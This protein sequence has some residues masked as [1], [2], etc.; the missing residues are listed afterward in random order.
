MWDLPLR[1]QCG[2]LRGT[3]RGVAP[4]TVN[5]VACGCRYCQRYV[6]RLGCASRVLDEHGVSTIFQVSPASLEITEGLEQLE[7]LFQTSWGARR[8]FA[9]CCNSPLANTLRWRSVP[10]VGVFRAAADDNALPVPIEQMLGP[11]LA[12]CNSTFPEPLASGLLARRRDVFRM[13]LRFFPMFM[14]WRLRGDHRR[15]SFDWPELEHRP[16][17]QA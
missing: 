12:T 11:R 8:W 5:H 3:V 10:F 7:S 1:C 17:L 4:D 16:K 13:V 9:S 6:E 14:G 15:W 2:A